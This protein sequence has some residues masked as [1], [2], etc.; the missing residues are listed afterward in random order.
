LFFWNLILELKKCEQQYESIKIENEDEVAR[1]YKL[2]K[3]L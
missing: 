2:K 1:Y 3:K